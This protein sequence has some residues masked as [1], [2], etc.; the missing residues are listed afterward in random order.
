MSDSPANLAHQ[1]GPVTVLQ[2]SQIKVTSLVLLSTR[3]VHH[4]RGSLVDLESFYDS[5]R[6]HN[7]ARGWW[8]LFGLIW[9]P[10]A[11][12]SNRRAMDAVASRARTGRA[13]AGF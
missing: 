7:L 8:S 12:N 11:L 6:T 3:K 10:R 4:Q 9:T 5:V 1:P 13:P 2:L